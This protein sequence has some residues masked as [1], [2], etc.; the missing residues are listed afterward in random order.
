[1]DIAS[2]RGIESLSSREINNG[3]SSKI[4][5]FC[6]RDDAK[7]INGI[8]Q[9]NLNFLK[10]RKRSIMR[11]F[12]IFPK[13]ALIFFSCSV[14]IWC[15]IVS[16]SPRKSFVKIN[17]VQ[18]LFQVKNTPRL[19]IEWSSSLHLIPCSKMIGFRWNFLK[20]IFQAFWP[21]LYPIVINNFILPRATLT[22]LRKAFRIVKHY[23]LTEF[24][25]RIIF[26]T[27]IIII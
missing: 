15:L 2:S 11:L 10:I 24:V 9:K 23:A 4:H 14:R 17:F 22:I 1:M 26:L 18:K 25:L 16:S 7:I 21:N 5:L 20:M 13:T 6:E 8:F 27:F 12:R 19:V 3:H